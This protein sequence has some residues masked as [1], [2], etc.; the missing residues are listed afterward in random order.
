MS[1]DG[2]D[3]RG[4]GGERLAV[5]ESEIKGLKESQEQIQKTMAA[6][7]SEMTRYKGFMGG[8][9]FLLSGVVVFWTMFGDYIKSHWHG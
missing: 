9:A 7:L 4:T 6:I 2:E 5:V 3:R 8:V 1:W